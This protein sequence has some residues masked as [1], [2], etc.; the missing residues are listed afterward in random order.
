MNL[1]DQE[2]KIEDLPEEKK[3]KVEDL[4]NQFDSESGK[5]EKKLRGKA[6]VY[7]R[8][9]QKAED[10]KKSVSGIGGMALSMIIDRMPVKSP[11]SEKE[12]L[13]FNL[14]FDNL[15]YKYAGYVE[16]FQ[17]ESA[18]LLISAMI[19]VPRLGLG[20]KKEKKKEEEPEKKEENKE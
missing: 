14:A 17:E 8:E 2:R 10:F 15:V 9:E 18:F 19:I 13:Q 1:P 20:Q 12:L 7:A 11:L 4:K 6:A 5:K 16:R 3:K